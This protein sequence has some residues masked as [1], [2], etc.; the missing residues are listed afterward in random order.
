M[1]S[2][3]EINIKVTIIKKDDTI[4]EFVAESGGF[5]DGEIFTQMPIDET[6][7]LIES[8]V[9]DDEWFC[10]STSLHD[11]VEKYKGI[12]ISKAE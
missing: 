9:D 6:S 1:E 4:H 12:A 11:I 8:F 10:Y 3:L 7:K 2:T 5:M